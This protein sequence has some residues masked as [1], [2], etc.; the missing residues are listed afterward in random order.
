MVRVIRSITQVEEGLIKPYKIWKNAFNIIFTNE[1][2]VV[3]R[4]QSSAVPYQLTR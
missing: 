4:Q 2:T 1:T 3:K